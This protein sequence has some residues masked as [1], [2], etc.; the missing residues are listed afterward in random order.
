MNEIWT[1]IFEDYKVARYA[2]WGSKHLSNWSRDE[3]KGY[4]HMFKAYYEALNAEE[5]EPLVFAR[6]LV[7]MGDE[8]DC[9]QSDYTRLHRYYLPAREQYELAVKAGLK[10]SDEELEHVNLYTDML[11][12]QF[13][14][15]DKNY[16]EQLSYI[17]GHERLTDFGFHDSK[18]IFFSHDKTSAVMKLQY[19]SEKVLELHFED[20]YDIK[21]HTDPVSDWINEFYCYPLFSCKEQL[22]FNIGFYKIICTKIFV[23]EYK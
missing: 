15:E 1:Q 13:E 11:V 2:L 19:D 6:I 5:K 20:I 22:I 4:Y 10:P 21:I 3:T 8:T 7:M 18:V 14:C 9:K 12:Y 16:Y 23:A 17:E